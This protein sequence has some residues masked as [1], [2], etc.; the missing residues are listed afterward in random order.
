MILYLD[1]GNTRLKWWLCDTDAQPV[2][3]GVVNNSDISNKSFGFEFQDER[4]ANR[5]AAIVFAQVADK[6][7][8]ARVVEELNRRF[9]CKIIFVEVERS[10]LGLEVA[11]RRLQNLGVDRWLNMLAVSEGESS[12]CAVV[13]SGT[14][15]TIDFLG[16]GSLGGGSRHRGGLIIPG[17]HILT[18][19]LFEKTS[20]SAQALTLPQKWA[21]EADTIPCVQSGV[22]ALLVGMFAEVL[23]GVNRVYLTG[24]DA[25]SISQYIKV[26]DLI[27]DPDLALK[28]MFIYKNNQP[29][30]KLNDV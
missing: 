5:V 10:F 16:G 1:A 15:I 28:G 24:G 14:A 19:T 17:L 4:V 27:I 6:S 8:S 22:A 13:S 11:Y 29:Q 9:D 26:D 3:S 12:D 2:E 23:Q 18:N 21:L 30:T 25:E 20:L 7:I